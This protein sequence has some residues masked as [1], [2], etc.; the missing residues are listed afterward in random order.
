VGLDHGHYIRGE[1]HGTTIGTGATTVAMI[2]EM[3][4]DLGPPEDFEFGLP[5][6]WQHRSCAAKQQF[7]RLTIMDG[8]EM[9]MFS[10]AGASGGGHQRLVVIYSAVERA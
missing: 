10:R 6:G 2:A 4:V 9:R 1:H 7:E 8:L 3:I 5:A